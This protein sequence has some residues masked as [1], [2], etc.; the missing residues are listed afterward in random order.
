MME[1]WIDTILEFQ[2]VTQYV[3]GHT[4][5]LADALSRSFDST[6]KLANIIDEDNDIG[7]SKHT[8]FEFEAY[9]HGK[10]IP[11]EENRILLLEQQHALGHFGVNAVVKKLWHDGYWWPNI[12][13]D[14]KQIVNSCIDCQRFNTIKE[15][16]HP[17]K[18]IEANQP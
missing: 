15:G 9:R 17:M 13:S 7:Q 16:F 12:R 11:D 6:I 14:V 3:P 10:S 4:N 2:F 1:G 8:K 5:D 18:S